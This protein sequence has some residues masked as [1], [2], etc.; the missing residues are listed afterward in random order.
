MN[1]VSLRY[2]D[3][4]LFLREPQYCAVEDM[5]AGVS[6]QSGPF[7]RQ[8]GQTL[9]PGLGNGSISNRRRSASTNS[10]LENPRR[11]SKPQRHLSHLHVPMLLLLTS[12]VACMSDDSTFLCPPA[13]CILSSMCICDQLVA[14][15]GRV[16]ARGSALQSFLP[17]PQWVFAADHNSPPPLHASHQFGSMLF[18]KGLR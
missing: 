4:R 6:P 14:A 18:H 10:S 8:M 5:H 12:H 2:R 7:H 1:G 13:S 3:G 9:S 15:G 17:P 16:V 11:P